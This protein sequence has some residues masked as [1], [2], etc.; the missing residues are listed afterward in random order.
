MRGKLARGLVD[1]WE[2][3]RLAV[4]AAEEARLV[5]ELWASVRWDEYW[6]CPFPL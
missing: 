3:Y 6:D 4:L 1:E 5:D 2:E